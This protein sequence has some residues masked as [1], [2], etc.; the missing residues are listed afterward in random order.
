MLLLKRKPGVDHMRWN[1]PSEYLIQLASLGELGPGTLATLKQALLPVAANCSKLRLH[2]RGFGGSPNVIQ[3]RYVH[4]EL[5]GD[6]ALLERLAQTIDAA[7]SRYVPNRDIRGFRPHI[8]IGRLK[9][10]SEPC[11]VG[12]GR[13]VKTTPMPDM[14]VIDVDSAA[15][16]ISNASEFGIGYAVVAQLPLGG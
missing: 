1:A 15:L 16:V 12:L 4:A 7:V 9:T 2:V 8:V 10:E 14:G 3:P 6:F 13:A 5:D 11:R